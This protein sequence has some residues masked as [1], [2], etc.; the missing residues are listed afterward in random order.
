M[1]MDMKMNMMSSSVYEEVRTVSGKGSLPTV[2]AY[3]AAAAG[4]VSL[5]PT[6]FE[7][8]DSLFK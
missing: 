4:L 2:E 3:G 5:P 7:P 6:P 8:E 1:N